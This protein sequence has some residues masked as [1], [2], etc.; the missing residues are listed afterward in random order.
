LLI[1]LFPCLGLAAGFITLALVFSPLWV[2]VAVVFGIRFLFETVLVAP[3][4][5]AAA[6]LGTVIDW[7]APSPIERQEPTEPITSISLALDGRRIAES[8]I[9]PVPRL[10]PAQWA[11]N[12]RLRALKLKVQRARMVPV[13]RVTPQPATENVPWDGPDYSWS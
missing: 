6:R 1:L 9:T 4:K 10:T 8:T 11:R 3:L 5:W 7:L 13:S 2:P 12:E